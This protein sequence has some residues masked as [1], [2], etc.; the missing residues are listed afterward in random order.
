[1]CLMP[2][3][4]MDF[5]DLCTNHAQLKVHKLCM[6]HT[7]KKIYMDPKKFCLVYFGIVVNRDFCEFVDTQHMRP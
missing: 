7:W 2:S 3:P 6:I 1:M 4:L 5:L